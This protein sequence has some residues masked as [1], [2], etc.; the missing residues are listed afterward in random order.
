MPRRRRGWAVPAGGEEDLRRHSPLTVSLLEP[1]LLILLREQSRH[2]YTLLGD[3]ENM[4]M[5]TIHPSVVYRSLR[6]MENLGWIES[7]WDLDQT[8]GPPRR[9]YRVTPQGEDALS[10][11]KVELQQTQELIHRLQNRINP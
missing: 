7:D 11:W 3:L 2:G 5:G 6:E 9:I 8:Q 1:A 4:G 10:H